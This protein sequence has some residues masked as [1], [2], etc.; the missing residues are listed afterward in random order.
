[1]QET[2]ISMSL[3]EYL[4]L[5]CLCHQKSFI[6]TIANLFENTYSRCGAGLQPGNSPVVS[7]SRI[8]RN[9]YFQEHLRL[10]FI[11]FFDRNISYSLCLYLFPQKNRRPVFFSSSVLLSI[12]IYKFTNRNS[13]G[14]CFRR[15]GKFPRERLQ[16]S[17]LL[18]CRLRTLCF[19]TV[20]D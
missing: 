9:T 7:F 10:F 2:F 4:F 18:G 6:E 5:G 11:F 14:Y 16:R 3:Y 1:M 19:L 20:S 8:I 12:V 17:S 13:C 15:F